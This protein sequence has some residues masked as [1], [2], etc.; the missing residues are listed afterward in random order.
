[1]VILNRVRKEVN[2][3][4]WLLN[5]SSVIQNREVLE[6]KLKSLESEYETKEIPVLNFGVD[7]WSNPSKLNFGRVGPTDFMT[8]F[9]INYKQIIS[10]KIDRLSP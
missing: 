9:V 4:R 1:M 10:W 8:A 6:A 2:W 7:L 3:E 5:Q